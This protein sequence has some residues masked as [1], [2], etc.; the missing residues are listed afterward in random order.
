MANTKKPSKTV[1][2]ERRKGGAVCRLPESIDRRV[3]LDCRVMV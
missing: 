3:T 2:C 1:S